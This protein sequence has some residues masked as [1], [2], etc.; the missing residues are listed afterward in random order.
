MAPNQLTNSVS[1]IRHFTTPQCHPCPAV[2]CRRSSHPVAIQGA[3]KAHIWIHP[4]SPVAHFQ[5][6]RHDVRSHTLH[7]QAMAIMESIEHPA[8]L[9]FLSS[10]FA[11]AQSQVYSSSYGSPPDSVCRIRARC[12]FRLQS[13]SHCPFDRTRHSFRM[14]PS[15]TPVFVAVC[16]E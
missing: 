11:S 13:V 16:S 9:P 10:L 1:H 15:R 7:W 6:D 3:N 14:D 5:E 8:D 4:K 2:K 12:P